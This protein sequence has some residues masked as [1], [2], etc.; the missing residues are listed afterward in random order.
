MGGGLGGGLAQSLGFWRADEIPQ[1]V[2]SEPHGKMVGN[3]GLAWPW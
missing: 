2:R 1:L 3:M